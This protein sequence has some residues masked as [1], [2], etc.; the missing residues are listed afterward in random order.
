[1]EKRGVS[2]IVVFG[3][4][5]LADPDLTYVVGGT[6][7]RGGV[8]FKRTGKAP[9]LLLSNLD[10]A[11][12]KRLGRVRRI[13]T[14]TDWGMEKL[15]K[16]YRR[17]DEAFAQLIAL[18]LRH[19]GVS[20]KVGLFGRTDLASGIRLADRL[21]R[22]GVRVVGSK[23]PTILESARETK[24]R[25]EIYEIRTAGTGT[26]RVVNEIVALLRNAKKKRG[27][28][29]VGRKRA[30][31]G[32]VKSLIATKLATKNLIPPEGTIFASGSSGADP[33]NMGV[34]TD[35]IRIGRLIVFDIFPQAT[36]GYWFDLTRTF[37]VGKAPPKARRMYQAVVEAQ[38]AAFDVLRAG[39][40]GEEAMLSACDAIESYGYRTVKEVYQGKSKT[41]Y[42]GFNHSLGHGVGL[43]I[44]ERPYLSLNSKDALT[45]RQVVTVEPG[46]Y[47]PKYGG[48]R[49]EDTVMVTKKG[50]DNLSDVP[51]ELELV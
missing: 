32:L 29:Y 25:T 45:E 27:H 40:S 11:T 43:T 5:T 12:A 19:E 7:P 23:S 31:I 8:Y 49:I 3:E 13:Q 51:K 50:F 2:G 42:S 46:V 10:I 28:L 20:G 39:V 35:E 26:S 24:D 14:Y 17:H 1:M 15:T 22:I 36:S 30:T 41:L 44:G 16:K 6:L 34:V 9:L 18:V 48:V 47:L 37:V 33:H 21:R 38:T 4:T